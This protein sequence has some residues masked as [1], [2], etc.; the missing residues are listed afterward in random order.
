M[1]LL[2]TRGAVVL[3]GVAVLALLPALVGLL[4]LDLVADG[5][6]V[7][8]V[9]VVGI[10]DVW[11]LAGALFVTGLEVRLGRLSSVT[12]LSFPLEAGLVTPLVAGTGLLTRAGLPASFVTGTE[13]L[14]RTGLVVPLVVGR[15]VLLLVGL[16][17]VLVPE[18]LTSVVLALLGRVV[19]LLALTTRVGL[20]S[21][22]SVLTF[23]L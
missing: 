22:F 20:A 16:V 5:L 9:V 8:D 2:F 4:V 10:L 11:L 12:F 15:A 14:T 21:L 13:V 19:I 18:F 1:V 6:E 3:V 7:V 17:V 23:G